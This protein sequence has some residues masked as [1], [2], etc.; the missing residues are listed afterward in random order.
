M[1]AQRYIY[2]RIYIKE[3]RLVPHYIEQLNLMHPIAHICIRRVAST[4]YT[5]VHIVYISDI[6][7]LYSLYITHTYTYVCFVDLL[8]LS[9]YVLKHLNYYCI[10]T[11][12]YSRQSRSTSC[13]GFVYV[14]HDNDS[15]YRERRRW[16][17]TRK[18]EVGVCVHGRPLA[19][20]TLEKAFK[21]DEE[22]YCVNLL[23]SLC[24]YLILL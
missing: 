22:V 14:H 13:Y 11:R 10:H 3:F 4:E 15:R 20:T 12:V 17:F 24:I 7:N 6:Y 19:N 5:K 21:E 1:H 8:F 2:S 16:V 18:S 23:H 9:L